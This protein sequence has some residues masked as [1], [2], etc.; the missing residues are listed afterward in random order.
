MRLRALNPSAGCSTSAVVVLALA[1][2]VLYPPLYG[3]QCSGLHTVFG[4]FAEDAF[5]YLTVARNST[6]TFLS[7]DGETRTNG[8]HPLWQYI[9]TATFRALRVH[10]M[11]TQLYLVFVLGAA[12]T[13]IGIIFAGLS[14][15]VLTRSILWP[16]LLVPGPFYILFSVRGKEDAIAHGITYTYSPWAFMNGMESPCSIML[17]G[18]FLYLMAKMYLSTKQARVGNHTTEYAATLSGKRLLVLGIVISLSVAARLDDVFLLLGSALFFLLWRGQKRRRA[19]N[20]LLISLPTVIFLG[21]Y[22]SYMFWTGQPWVPVSGMVKGSAGAALSG[23]VET[24]LCDMFPPIHTLLRPSYRLEAWDLTAVRSSALFFPLA[25][26]A[27]LV[28]HI[29]RAGRTAPEEYRELKWLLPIL[30]YILGKGLYN[31]INVRVGSQG[32]WYYALPILMTNYVAILLAWRLISRWPEGALSR[33]KTVL[34]VFYIVIYLFIASNTIYSASL[35]NQR[36]FT[37]YKDSAAISANLKQICPDIRIIDRTDAQYA[38]F[39]NIPAVS[40]LGYTVDYD[41]YLALK[42][43]K[44]LDYCIGRGFTVTFE[45][46]RVHP[47]PIPRDGYTLTEIYKDEPSETAFFKIE[48]ATKK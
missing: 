45:N 7:F 37:L 10:D 38:Y 23:N 1:V 4:Y 18:I 15:H 33:A 3:L 17:G 9:L 34:G 36:L 27:C 29:A 43:G 11:Q 46:S 24:F 31:V 30:L 5:Y 48:R 12:I 21:A 8:F 22:G 25:L 16:L 42:Q 41:G 2:L 47:F 13:T 6:I 28:V 40:A 26:A 32:Y 14:L 39:L 44:F 19:V 35:G 20:I